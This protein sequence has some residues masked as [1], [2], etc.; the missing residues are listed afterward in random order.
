MVQP[1]APSKAWAVLAYTVADDKG[2]GRTLDTAAK[3]ELMAICDASDFAEVSVAAQVDFTHTRGV[4]RAVLTEAP[5]T[6]E[7]EDVLP[8]N[9]PLW[10]AV[11][12]KLTQSALRLQMEREDLNAAR[13]SVLQ[14]FLTFGHAECPADR[15]VIFFYGHAHGPMGLFF[16]K[17]AGRRAP[18]TSLRLNDLAQSMETGPRPAALVVFRDCFMNTLEAAYQFRGVAEFM[19]ASQ[20]LVPVSGI[21]PWASLMSSLMPSASSADQ[22]LAFA[23]GLG[24]FLDT[25]AN[26]APFHDA[27]ISLLDLSAA[28]AIIAPLK[29]LVDA[30]EDARQDRKQSTTCARALEKARVGYPHERASPGDPSL[31]DVPTMCERLQATGIEPVAAAA[32]HLGEVVATRLV[33]W[34]HAQQQSHRGTSIYYKPATRHDK[35]HSCIYDEEFFEEDAANYRQLALCTATGWDRIALN[36]LT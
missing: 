33:R 20:S 22:A 9:H 13:G 31:L 1:V 29:A 21:W 35:D 17:D 10:R 16:D 25:D 7:F 34:H 11:V 8:E 14:D 27:P 18:K 2:G 5:P 6:R 23:K 28:D 26:R 3:Q 36:P 30:L 15:H 19:I 32:T 12:A 4:F 24:R